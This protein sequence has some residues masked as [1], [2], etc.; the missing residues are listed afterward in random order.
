[1]MTSSNGYT[2]YI[3]GPLWGNLPATD[4]DSK[5]ELWYFLCYQPEYTLDQIVELVVIWEDKTRMIAYIYMYIYIYQNTY[6]NDTWRRWTK[7]FHYNYANIRS[8]ILFKANM[9][10]KKEISKITKSPSLSQQSI[11]IISG[12]L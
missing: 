4:R 11:E 12:I 8:E 7:L 9:R 2:L 5:A 1:M 6:D 3:P 10:K